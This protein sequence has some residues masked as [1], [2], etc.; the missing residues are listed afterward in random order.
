MLCYVG[1]GPLIAE[2]CVLHLKWNLDHRYK[3]DLDM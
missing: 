3:L 2:L 1:Q